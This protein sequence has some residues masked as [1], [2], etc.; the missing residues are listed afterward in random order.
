MSNGGADVVAK[1]TPEQTRK[2]QTLAAS[3]DEAQEQQLRQSLRQELG[4]DFNAANEVFE[5]SKLETISDA[6]AATIKGRGT[7]PDPPSEMSDNLVNIRSSLNNPRAVEAFD[8]KFAK[9]R[10][11][12][13]AME[14]AMEGMRRSG[15]DIEARMLKD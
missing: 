15:S 12:S 7:V 6:E 1:L 2:F 13:E 14:R 3:T 9:M 4:D 10:G 11:N 5:G 8:N